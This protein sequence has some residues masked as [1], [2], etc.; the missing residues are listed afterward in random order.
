[1]ISALA[2]SD[3]EYLDYG[4]TLAAL[5]FIF[6][7]VK[8]GIGRSVLVLF[9]ILFIARNLLVKEGLFWFSDLLLICLLVGFLGSIMIYSTEIRH[10]FNQLGAKNRHTK[11]AALNFIVKHNAASEQV[12]NEIEKAMDKLKLQGE[13][14]LIIIEDKDKA[15]AYCSSGKSVNAPVSADLLISI[16]QK[17]SPFHDG[18][19]LIANNQI[20]EAGLV[21]PLSKND[22]YENHGTRHKAALG[23]SELCDAEVWVLSEERGTL[24]KVKHGKI[25]A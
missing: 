9:A 25:T 11:N 21:L 20:I 7:I 6:Y 18:A 22:T 24:S 8:S 16:F 10:F 4:L 1:M 5:A 23:I 13:G 12:L 14:A 3:T 17:T 15:S 19:V 2:I